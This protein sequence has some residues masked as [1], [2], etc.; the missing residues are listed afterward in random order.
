MTQSVTLSSQEVAD[1]LGYSKRHFLRIRDELHDR[2]G[3]PRPLV[4]LRWDA[5][6]L[7]NWRSNP[8][9]IAP[10]QQPPPPRRLT[11]ADRQEAAEANIARL[12]NQRRRRGKP[13]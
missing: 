5:E 9:A 8:P 7:A 12:A 1:L 3:F 13:N 4:G 10:P 2:N 6:Q 11:E